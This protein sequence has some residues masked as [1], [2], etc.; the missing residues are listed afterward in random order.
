MKINIEQT[1]TGL[2]SRVTGIFE[3]SQ[4]NGGLNCRVTSACRAERRR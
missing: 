4:T 1:T 2:G 3:Y